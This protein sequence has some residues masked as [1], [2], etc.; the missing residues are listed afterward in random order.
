MN[1]TKFNFY[2]NAK[3][4]LIGL[5][6]V[7]L[8]GLIVG[9]VLGLNLA[10]ALGGSSI[11]YFT[12]SILIIMVISFIYLLLRYDSVTAFC[13]A[14][15]LFLNIAT[16]IALVAIIRVPVADNFISV[17]LVTSVLTYVFNLI[18]F[19]KIRLYKNEKENR[20]VVVNKSIKESFS[21]ILL[22]TLAIA[23]V[24]ILCL[25]ILDTSIYLFVRPMLISLATCLVTTIFVSGPIWGFFYRERPKKVKAKDDTIFVEANEDKQ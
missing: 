12:L 20:D 16:V 24:L 15:A 10:E 9:L 25:A 3:Y 13:F 1:S 6:V 22:T 14:L 23:V 2:K 11:V 7:L 5:G 4:I 18:L 8:A 21:Y 19:S 17:L